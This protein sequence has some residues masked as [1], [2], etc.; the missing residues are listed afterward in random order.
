MKGLIEISDERFLLLKKIHDDC[1]KAGI[2]PP[3]DVRQALCDGRPK[4]VRLDD[5]NYQCV[6]VNIDH[7]IMEERRM[8]GG[9]DRA[10]DLT[11]LDKRIT[12]IFIKGDGNVS[13][14]SLRDNY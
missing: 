3:E 12:K 2:E 4:I 13:M 9:G 5:K 8:Y 14:S 7:A 10:I 11:K 1:L 6:L